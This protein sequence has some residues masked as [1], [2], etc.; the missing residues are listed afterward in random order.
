MTPRPI[1]LAAL[2]RKAADLRDEWAATPA[3]PPRHRGTGWFLKGPVPW[4]WLEATARLP[5][6]ALALGLVLWRQAGCARGRTVRVCLRRAGLGLGERT[7][8]RGLRNLGRAG[9]LTARPMS[10]RGVEVTLPDPRGFGRAGFLRGPV[11]WGWLES[12]ARLPGQALAVSLALWRKAGMR[13]RRT[14]K[15]CLG[16][17]GLGVSK[18]AA[19]RAV[20]ALEQAGLVTVRRLP[21]RG[22]EVTLRDAPPA[23]PAP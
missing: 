10:G 12:A 20:R 1:D 15:L 2:R 21:G 16:R 23:G 3:G 19:R 13:R 14:V 11:P 22:L 18:Q 7:A 8:R 5:G 17:V 6:S 9:L 4:P